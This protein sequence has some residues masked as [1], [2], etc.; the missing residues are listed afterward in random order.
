MSRDVGGGGDDQSLVWGLVQFEMLT[1]QPSGPVELAG[2]CMNP[3]GVWRDTYLGIRQCRKGTREVIC[4]LTPSPVLFPLFLSL[5]GLSRSLSSL[6][7][8]PSSRQLRWASG[9]M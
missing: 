3:G 1:R 2:G 9:Q 6:A 4:L 8:R 5:S 7:D